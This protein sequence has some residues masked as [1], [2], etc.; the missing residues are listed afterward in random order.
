VAHELGHAAERRSARAELLTTG[1]AASAEAAGNA[2]IILE[3]AERMTGI[4]Q[5]LLDFSRR[6]T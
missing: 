2:R 6:R 3:Q 4:I 5:S 1:T